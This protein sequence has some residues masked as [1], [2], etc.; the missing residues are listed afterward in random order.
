MLKLTMAS[1]AN[2]INYMSP[3]CI[4][5]L[6]ERCCSHCWPGIETSPLRDPLRFVDNHDPLLV[7][8]PTDSLGR[9]KVFRLNDESP[10]EMIA[11]EGLQMA[12]DLAV[13]ES[14]KD[15]VLK[16]FHELALQSGELF[17]PL[18]PLTYR[19]HTQEGPSHC[20]RCKK[21]VSFKS[22]SL[23]CKK[24]RK[25]VCSCGSCVCGIEAAINWLGQFFSS[26]SLRFQLQEKTGSSS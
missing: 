6:E 2:L 9:V 7:L 3:K 11:E 15:E 18:V 24:C 14:K 19:E 23:G 4:H 20:G 13:H 10:I 16:Q 12:V 22:G 26:N 25:Y 21:S 8:R 1:G 17:H 5:Q